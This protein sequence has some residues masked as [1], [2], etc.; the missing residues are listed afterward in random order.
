MGMASGISRPVTAACINPSS[1]RPRYHRLFFRSFL[2]R[3]RLPRSLG[4]SSEDPFAQRLGGSPSEAMA[5]SSSRSTVS[6]REEL[7]AAKKAALLASHLCQ[8][9]QKSIMPSDVQSKADKSPVT[10]ADY[11]SQALI[12]LVLKMELPSLS[13]S[14]VA[15]EDSVDLQKDVAHETLKS[16]TKLVNEILSASDTYKL[17]LSEEE[18]LDAIDSGK[19]EGGPHGRHWVLDPIDGTKGFLRGDQ[20]AIALAMLDEGKVALGVLA[21]PNLPLFS[22]R[23]TCDQSFNSEIGCIFSA[24]LGSGALMESLNGST[25]SKVHVSTIEAPADASFFESFEA[26]HS[27]HDLSSSIAEKLGVRAP[28]VRIDS[29]AKY[30]AMARGDGA[31][32]LRFPHKG[33]R[34]KIWD[35]AAGFIVVS[36]AGGLV[37]DAAGN[38]LDFSRGRH[39]DLDTGIICTNKKL[40]P[41]LLK[42]VQDSLKEKLQSPSTLKPK[43]NH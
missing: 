2:F 6:Y 40:M 32:Y 37:S 43:L 15:E 4:T 10:V 16:I 18:V 28:P 13:F 33:Y 3:R 25:A 9:V 41:L 14:L 42:A 29:Q 19:S 31:I 5:S 24:C 35:H 17:S 21:C 39:L 23:S 36:E 22:V 1:C 27:M 7:A 20:Y 38:E 12:S 11:G 8:K 26:A 30:A 34:E